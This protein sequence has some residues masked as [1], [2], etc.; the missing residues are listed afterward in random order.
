LLDTAAD[1]Y[2]KRYGKEDGAKVVKGDANSTLMSEVEGLRNELNT[3]RTQREQE[4]SRIALA[5]VKSRYDARV[6]DL[7]NQLPKESGLTGSER[8]ALRARVDAELSQDSAI[9]QR[10]ASGNFVDVPHK[11]KAILDEW[12]GDRKAATVAADNRRKGISDNANPEFTGGPNPFMPSDKAF[13]DSWDNTEE[14]FAKA[15]T[16]ASR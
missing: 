3:F 10:V 7:F 12:V 9:V 15:L 8:K 13:A 1:E 2:V 5:Q 16:Q 4:Q 6:D 11:F 14:A